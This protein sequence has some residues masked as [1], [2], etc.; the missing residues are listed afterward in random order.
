MAMFRFC[1]ISPDCIF[2]VH[3]LKQI[4]WNRNYCL[5]LLLKIWVDG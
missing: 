1:V 5:A 4:E 3:V 2:V